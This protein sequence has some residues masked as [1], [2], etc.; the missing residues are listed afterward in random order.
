MRSLRS[1]NSLDVPFRSGARPL[2]R[3]QRCSSPARRSRLSAVL[4]RG[5]LWAFADQTEMTAVA[6]ESTGGGVALPG[7]SPLVEGEP[8]LADAGC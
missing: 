4:P 3:G 1:T 7:V 2:S 8:R 6:A 5:L